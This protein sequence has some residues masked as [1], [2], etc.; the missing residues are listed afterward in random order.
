[1]LYAFWSVLANLMSMSATYVVCSSYPSFNTTTDLFKFHSTTY[2]PFTLQLLSNELNFRSTK[3]L[4]MPFDSDKDVYKHTRGGTS[5]RLNMTRYPVWSDNCI[6]L[7][8]TCGCWNIVDGTEID[9]AKPG[10]PPQQIEDHLKWTLRYN[11][12]VMIISSSCSD[13]VRPYLT[14][15]D[16]PNTI[17]ETL[18]NELN[19]TTTRPGR[20]TVCRTFFKITC[21]LC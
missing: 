17:R 19:N 20:Q 15:N 3:A 8:T 12:T 16:D 2:E 13:I 18:A 10:S 6:H 7:L 21:V 14:H 9:P 5:D 1:M 4:I 11:E